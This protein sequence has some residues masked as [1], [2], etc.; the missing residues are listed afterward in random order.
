MKQTYIKLFIGVMLFITW[1]ALVVFRVPGSDDLITAIKACLL[2]L[3]VYHLGARDER[4]GGAAQASKEGG[5]ALPGFLLALCVGTLAL[6]GC[7]TQGSLTPLAPGQTPA[8]K[9]QVSYTQ[10]CAAWDA[11]FQTA[12]ELRRAGK[13]SPLQV[14]RI[15][16]LDDQATPLCT[17]PMP[18]DPNAAAQQVTAAVTALAILEAVQPLEKK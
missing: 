8:Q 1:I 4:I 13:L 3:G 9:M 7:M 12:L 6:S 10:A 15:S 17:G 11:G 5:R 14:Q 18:T 16:L 2:G